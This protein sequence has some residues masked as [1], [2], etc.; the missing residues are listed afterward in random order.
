MREQKRKPG[1]TPHVLKGRVADYR[2][3][4]RTC[5]GCGKPFE[6]QGPGNRQCQRC[7][8]KN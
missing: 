1:R 5:L 3:A 2:P 7:K 6:S 4:K 8:A